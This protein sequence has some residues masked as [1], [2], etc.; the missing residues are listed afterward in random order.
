M[1]EAVEAFI[2]EYPSWR[3]RLTNKH[4]WLSI[5]EKI[6][7][8][9]GSLKKTDI[10][11]WLNDGHTWGME[12][13]FTRLMT[14]HAAIGVREGR[15]VTH[16]FFEKHPQLS[17]HL[18]DELF[19]KM[20]WQHTDV[21]T[22]QRAREQLDK[23]EAE[24]VPRIQQQSLAYAGWLTTNPIYRDELRVIR[25]QWESL[26]EPIPFPLTIDPFKG[27]PALFSD[28]VD[29]EGIPKA[30]VHGIAPKTSEF[31]GDLAVFF[32]RWGITRLVDWDYPVPQGPLF[33][34]KEVLSFVRNNDQTGQVIY[35]PS[36]YEVIASRDNVLDILK[37]NQRKVRDD[38]FLEGDCWPI[39]HHVR[40]A[41]MFLSRHALNA[42]ELRSD[43]LKSN[44]SEHDMVLR[45]ISEWLDEALPESRGGTNKAQG[46]GGEENSDHGARARN[47][48][49]FA[50]RRLSGKM[51]QKLLPQ[52]ER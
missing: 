24:Q 25:S 19:D 31:A 4:L 17:S 27:T 38:R 30:D 15:I 33:G 50:N 9:L 23:A 40:Y 41:G 52:K 2:G 44:S 43:K 21:K 14:Q 36:W 7:D 11:A 12:E 32:R 46:E 42:I 48:L 6:L 18:T 10:P 35:I 13:R 3:E 49:N 22:A 26:A 45:L 34:E 28:L 16:P 51:P 39:T 1:D 47:I 20:G 29:D 5:P 37:S 8:G